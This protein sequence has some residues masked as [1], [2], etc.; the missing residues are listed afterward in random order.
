MAVGYVYL[1]TNGRDYKIGL[2]SSEPEAR[3]RQLQT[4]SSE[5]IRLVAYTI[6][7]DMN[8]LENKLHTQFASKRKAGEWF[9]LSEDNLHHIYSVFK[10]KSISIDMS[11][12]PEIVSKDIDKLM[13]IDGKRLANGE[14]TLHDEKYVHIPNYKE[15]VIDYMHEEEKRKKEEKRRRIESLMKEEEEEYRLEELLREDAKRIFNGEKPLHTFEYKELENWKIDLEEEISDLKCQEEERKETE[16]AR[17][18]EEIEVEEAQRRFDVNTAEYEARQAERSAG[19]PRTFISWKKYLPWSMKHLFE[20]EKLDLDNPEI[21]RDRIIYI[22]TVLER[23]KNRIKP[24]TYEPYFKGSFKEEL[25]H[26]REKGRRIYPRSALIEAAVKYL[27]R[28]IG[29]DG[30]RIATLSRDQALEQYNKYVLE[31]NEPP[32]DYVGEENENKLT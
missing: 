10:Q 25:E 17:K 7:K 9:E 31:H 8:S 27:A 23:I 3:K 12:I 15:I 30:F 21:V 2:T 19:T 16:E 1:M 13:K 22:L 18:R 4:G 14:N 29:E 20:D 28:T 5:Q 6:C 24:P 26:N 32:S 11:L